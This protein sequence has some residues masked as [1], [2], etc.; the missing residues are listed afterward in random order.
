MKLFK[1]LMAL[2]LVFICIIGLSPVSAAPAESVQLIDVSFSVGYLS[3]YEFTPSRTWYQLTVPTGTDNI[4][5]SAIP[6]NSN[7][8][9]D[10][11]GNKSMQSINSKKIVIT[12]LNG[13]SKA[14]YTFELIYS[15][16][17]VTTTTTTTTSKVTT[18]TSEKVTTTTSSSSISGETTT[19]TSPIVSEPEESTT[20]SE[21]TISTTT[22]DMASSKL[23]YLGIKGE[24]LTKTFASNAYDYSVVV[25]NIDGDFEIETITVSPNAEVNVNR[26]GNKFVVEVQNGDRKS[27]YIIKLNQRNS[28]SNSSLDSQYIIVRNAIIGV[29]LLLLSIVLFILSRRLKEE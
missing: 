11:G 19:S 14:Y 12:V 1:K 3:K 24:K 20:T 23:S 15:N 29:I 21:T 7:A 2:Y 4:E 27:T 25:D 16:K 6:K 26:N 10:I 22:I 5:V 18:T 9:I 28:A 17:A 8:T 13:S